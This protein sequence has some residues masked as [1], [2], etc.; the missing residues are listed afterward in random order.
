MGLANPR[1]HRCQRSVL[2]GSSCILHVSRQLTLIIILLIKF[3]LWKFHV[4][5]FLRQSLTEPR[6]H[7]FGYNGLTSK[8]QESS[9]LQHTA[10]ELQTHPAVFHG[11]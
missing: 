8:H 3:V 4:Y 1:V 5:K 7:H 2:G 9:C 10:L 11:C 6:V